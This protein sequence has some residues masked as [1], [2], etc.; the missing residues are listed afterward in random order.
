MFTRKSHHLVHS[1]R[2]VQAKSKQNFVLKMILRLQ[3]WQTKAFDPI[4][5]SFI[6]FSMPEVFII[7]PC[8]I[9]TVY[10]HTSYISKSQ[11][12]AVIN[13]NVL[14]RPP[15]QCCLGVLHCTSAIQNNTW[16]L[17]GCL[18]LHYCIT[19]Q[20]WRVLSGCPN[21]HQPFSLVLTIL[22][23]RTNH[24]PNIHQILTTLQ[25]ILHEWFFSS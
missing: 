6:L 9:H 4:P 13:E 24:H 22:H 1:T 19:K 15:L 12:Y 11:P 7:V 23:T 17:S 20:Y 18:I 25:N 16:V 10:V 2:N 3:N 14:H 8:V 5:L 21:P